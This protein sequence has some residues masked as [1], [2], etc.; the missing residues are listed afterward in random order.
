[1][2]DNWEAIEASRC[3]QN[4]DEEKITDNDD[5]DS[6]KTEARMEESPEKVATVDFSTAHTAQVQRSVK[7]SQDSSTS[8]STFNKNRPCSRRIRR[9]TTNSNSNSKSKSTTGDEEK[10]T[11][12]DDTDSDKT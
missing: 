8:R 2:R 12:N 7:G 3:N 5:T 6:D 11:D 9:H 10:I 4:G 1:M